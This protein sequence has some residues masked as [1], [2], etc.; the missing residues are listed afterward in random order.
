MFFVFVYLFFSII[1]II[2]FYEFARSSRE[3]FGVGCSCLDGMA[4]ST[5]KS[6]LLLLVN[7]SHFLAFLILPYYKLVVFLALVFFFFFFCDDHYTI[8]I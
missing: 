3:I 1:I 8:Y 7:D 6:G 4:C 5:N 2:I